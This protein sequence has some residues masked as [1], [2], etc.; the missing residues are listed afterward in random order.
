MAD[1]EALTPNRSLMEE[2]A[3]LFNEVDKGKTTWKTTWKKFEEG[4]GSKT[5]EQE[6]QVSNI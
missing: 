2:A 5:T 1:Q 6:E 4:S 3:E